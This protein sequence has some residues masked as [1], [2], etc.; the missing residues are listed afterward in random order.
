MY[1]I[2]ANVS[3]VQGTLAQI[4]YA[5]TTYID[6]AKIYIQK[7]AGHTNCYVIDA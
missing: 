3:A 7:H 6:T 5:V 2:T 4:L 1:W